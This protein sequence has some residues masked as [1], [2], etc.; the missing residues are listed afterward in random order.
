MVWA[1]RKVMKNDLNR[2]LRRPAIL[3]NLHS[4][5]LVPSHVF[6][7]KGR[8]QISVM[9]ALNRDRVNHRLIRLS[10]E[11]HSGAK[12]RMWMRVYYKTINVCVDGTRLVAAVEDYPI[13]SD[14]SKVFCGRRP[15][16][17]SSHP[18]VMSKDKFNSTPGER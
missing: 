1:L 18:P 6:H 12:I 15:M 5:N 14:A 4:S 9:N 3:F 16:R 17:L 8:V 13:R 10:D 2:L 7:L 11:R